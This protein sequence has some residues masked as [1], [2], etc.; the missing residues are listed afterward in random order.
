[1]LTD[2]EIEACRLAYRTMT[3]AERTAF[4]KEVT[5]RAHAERDAVVRA[6]FRWIWSMLPNLRTVAQAGVAALRN[7]W[8]AY[9][10]H[11]KRKVAVSELLS[12]D[13]HMLKDMGLSRSEVIAVVYGEDDSRLPPGMTSR[14]GRDR[15]DACVSR[16]SAR[17][18]QVCT[19]PI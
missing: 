9:L 15:V 1:M 11:R 14:K 19:S 3:P 12:L 10:D 18:P 6:T 17:A 8:T 2:D 5:R 4:R 16:F 7:L 13:D